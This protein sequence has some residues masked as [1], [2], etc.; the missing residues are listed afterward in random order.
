MP[1]VEDVTLKG[2][3]AQLERLTLDHTS[4][5]VAAA[6]TDRSTFGLTTVPEAP[7]TESL[8]AVYPQV[9]GSFRN[10]AMFY[11]LREE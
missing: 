3:P 1:P 11:L 9:M 10:S 4:A 5:I 7:L 2:K 8:V 6:S